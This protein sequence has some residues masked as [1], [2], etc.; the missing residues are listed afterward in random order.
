MFN[1]DTTK[2]DEHRV[3]ANQSDMF[4]HSQGLDALY[5][6][7]MMATACINYNWKKCALDKHESTDTVI[8]N[9]VIWST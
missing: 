3:N 2:Q 6:I 1:L 4:A 8:E 9:H 7:A 5:E